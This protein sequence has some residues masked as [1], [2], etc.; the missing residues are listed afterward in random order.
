M[1]STP[2]ETPRPRAASKTSVMV[3]FAT[4][5]ALG[6]LRPCTVV[7]WEE[8]GKQDETQSG[9]GKSRGGEGQ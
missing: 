4:A 8:G 2:R 5:A 3:G 6:I 7:V 9:A 1:S